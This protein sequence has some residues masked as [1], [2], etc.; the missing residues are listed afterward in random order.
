[1]AL[2]HYSYSTLS[3]FDTCPYAFYLE[4]VEGV[5]V[6]ENAFAQHGSLCHKLLE[7]WSKGLL[8]TEDL[9]NEYENRFPIHVTASFPRYISG[10][11][12]RE[13]VFEKVKNYFD[14]F[15]QF[16]GYKV[17]ASEQEF[18]TDIADRKF[19]GVIDLVLQ[20]AKGNA[21]ICDHK[22]KSLDSFKKSEKEMY[23]QQYLYS[24]PYFE[25]FGEYPKYLMFN[26]F[27]ENLQV[28]KEFKKEDYDEA[29]GWAEGIIRKIE[30]CGILDFLETKK[31]DFYCTEICNV[32]KNCENGK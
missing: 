9:T 2:E 25:H 4:K 29:I 19:V 8:K 11:K 23:R 6:A 14:S 31:K 7:E 32:R 26:L 30:D 22:S 17:L 12:H 15:D 3:L 20:D 21:I 28:M 16:A 27:Q 18:E 13:K 5:D 10:G 1:M 24:K